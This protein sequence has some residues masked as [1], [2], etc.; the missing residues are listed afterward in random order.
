MTSYVYHLRNL[1]PANLLCTQRINF[2]TRPQHVTA[3]S[4][5]VSFLENPCEYPHRLYCQKP[6]Y[7]IYMT[8]AISMVYLY[9]ILRNCFRNPRKDVQDER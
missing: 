1:R 3:L 7:M 9:L 6:E 4:F 2:S 5:D 8:A